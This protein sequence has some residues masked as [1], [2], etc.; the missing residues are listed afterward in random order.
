[1]CVRAE[2]HSQW[3]PDRA[4]PAAVVGG[5]T[6]TLSDALIVTDGLQFGDIAKAR[7]AIGQLVHQGQTIETVAAQV[8]SVAV[9]K[10]TREIQEMIEEHFADPVYRV[11]DIIRREPLVP[12]HLVFVGGAGAGL[13]PY[14]T[15]AWSKAIGRP[16]TYHTPAFAGIANAVGAA[17][18][19]PT[20]LDDSKGRYRAGLFF[21]A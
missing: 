6:P 11:E 3:G 9:E 10:I 16:C 2:R 20:L 18:A 8:L 13:A 17:V 12:E 19:R 5:L 1:M 21:C 4:D 15:S 14:V 7:Q